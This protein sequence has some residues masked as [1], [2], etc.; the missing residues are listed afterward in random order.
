M[1]FHPMTLTVADQEEIERAL[2]VVHAPDRPDLIAA[3][4]ALQT[5]LDVLARAS[6]RP[7]PMELPS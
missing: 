6:R 4:E 7:T 1:K 3:M 5:V 2:W